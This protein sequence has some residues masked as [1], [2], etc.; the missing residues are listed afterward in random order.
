VWLYRDVI[1]LKL[2][3]PPFDA[4]EYDSR[5]R[6][7]SGDIELRYQ[8]RQSP[9]TEPLACRLVVKAASLHSTQ[10]ALR[11]RRIVFV[12]LRGMDGT[13]R[14]LSMLD[15]AGNRIEVKQDWPWWF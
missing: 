3:P 4:R 7:R 2:V 6:F 5:L 9:E 10:T 1:G 13:D 14:R 8:L 15:P 12:R 11:A